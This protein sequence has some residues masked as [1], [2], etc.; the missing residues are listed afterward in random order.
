MSSPE[1]RYTTLDADKL[2]SWHDRAMAFLAEHGL[3]PHPVNFLVAYE[4]VRGEDQELTRQIDEHIAHRL[5]W[6]DALMGVLF[7]RL[8]DGFRANPYP[9]VSQ[10]LM[11]LLTNLLGQVKDAHTSVAGYHDFLSEKQSNLT[12]RDASR[13]TLHAIVSEIMNATNEV[14]LTTGGLQEK[15]DSTQRE[16]ESLRRQ[17]EEI[18]REAEHD[19]LTGALNRKALEHILDNLTQAADMGGSGFSLLVADVD[20]FKKFNDSYGHLLGDEVLKRVV[21]SM[22]QQ[23]RGSDYV[24]RY[25]GEEFVLLLPDTPLHGAGIVAESIRHAVEQIVLIRRSNKERLSNISV[26]IGVGLYVPGEGKLSI[27]ERVDSALYAAKHNGRN[28]VET[29][30]PVIETA[31]HQ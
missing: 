4:Y 25:G 15:L 3:T 19:A 22:H 10:E 24:A 14:V 31:T 26:S 29:A 16:A 9:E 18:R 12:R 5:S 13:E 30:L 11:A 7:E 8:I 20:H 28:R 1:K 17:L 21:Q 23:V 2:R 27:M 6:N